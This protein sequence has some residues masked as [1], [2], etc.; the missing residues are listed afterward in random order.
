MIYQ[1]KSVFEGI[2]V[3]EI[4]IY[5]KAEY[6]PDGNTAVDW[7]NEIRRV[8]DA[9]T[10][11]NRQL[12]GLYEESYNK[13]GSENAMIF[14]VHKMILQDEGYRKAICQRIS[15]EKVSAESAVLMAGKQ[16]GE[17]FA[18]LDDDRMRSRAADIEDVSGR[19]I[20]ILAGTQEPETIPGEPVILV[21]EELSPSEIV[22]LD[23]ENVL[24]YVAVKG[25][26][27]SHGAI[28]AKSMGIPTL[29]N[30]GVVLASELHG[31]TAVVDGFT[32]EFIIQPEEKI[33]RQKQQ[34]QEQW[35]EAR[36]M[37][38]ELKTKDNRTTDGRQIGLCANIGS[39]PEVESVLAVNA[40]GIGLFRSEFL[41]LERDSYP[42]EEE[43]FRIY[44]D[45]LI[46]MQGKKVVFRTM[47]IGTDKQSGYMELPEE[48][49]PA[50]G[51]RAIRICLER[52]DI[53]RIQLRAIYRA[54]VFGCGAVM[55]PM[56]ISLAEIRAVKA[57]IAEV[58]KEL[59]EEGYPH[60]EVEIGIMIET[61]AAALISDDLA[62]E[63]DFFSIGT[64]D[65][66]QFVLAVD[67]QNPRLENLYDPHHQAVLKLIRMTVE[68]AHQAGIRVGICGELA[69]EASYTRMFL[70]MG[71]DELSVNPAYVLAIRK[72]IREI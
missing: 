14:E 49:N 66:T 53:F 54:S 40:D 37:L 10:E 9:I 56:I 42:S 41:Y 7:Q 65:L 59:K 25:S 63:V 47:D 61:P 28:L 39:L 15:G 8:E 67:R 32:G 24:A 27:N 31:K 11:A 19:L 35:L 38:E 50:M 71:V 12:T 62:K 29:M 26:V 13:F 55:F 60:G 58:K 20:R 51:Y 3:G 17:M 2:A 30:T 6:V 64:N 45:V 33:L 46:R 44:K 48:E 22:R 68:N 52:K 5:R 69:A 16:V 72:N 4:F 34:A 43:Q 18:A 21:A 57:V 70:D 1:G 23:K 36:K